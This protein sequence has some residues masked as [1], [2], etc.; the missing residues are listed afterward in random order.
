M[1]CQ[2]GYTFVLQFFMLISDGLGGV[3]GIYFFL[4]AN[5]IKLQFLE[6]S[7]S[8]YKLEVVNVIFR[9]IQITFYT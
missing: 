7:G 4:S 3:D 2:S 5:E 9:G 1:G 8:Q 6:T